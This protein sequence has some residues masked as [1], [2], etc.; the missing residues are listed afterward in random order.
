MYSGIRRGDYSLEK[1]RI[2]KG[3]GNEKA[4]ISWKKLILNYFG[5]KDPYVFMNKKFLS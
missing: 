2:R 1:C 5:K 4:D 3:L